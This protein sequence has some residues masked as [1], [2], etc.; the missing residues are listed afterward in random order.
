M[1]LRSKLHMEPYLLSKYYGAG[2]GSAIKSGVRLPGTAG[3]YISTPDSVLNSVMGD[4]DIRVYCKLDDWTPAA[5]MSL[6]A[7][8]NTASQRSFQIRVETNGRA[9]YVYSV[10]GN[11]GYAATIAYDPAYVDGTAHWIRFTHDVDNGAGG[12]DI[13]YYTSDDG[14]TWALRGTQTN[15]GITGVIS[16]FDSTSPLEIGSI[17]SGTAQNLLGTVYYAEVRNGIDGPVVAKFDSSQVAVTGAQLPATINGWTW[18]GAALYK[19]DDY[20][21]LPGANTDFLSYPGTAVNTI[22]GDIDVRIKLS[23]D[24]T[25]ATGT[26]AG[27]RSMICQHGGGGVIGWEFRSRAD[28]LYLEYSLD[29]TNSHSRASG[30]L[31]FADGII[32]WVRFTRVVSTGV[33]VFYASD[34]G[35]TWSIVTT[36]AALDAGS[37]FFP[38]QAQPIRIGKRSD[39]LAL[40]GNVY[41]AEVRNGINGPVVA[42]FNGADNQVQTPWTINGAAWNWEGSSFTGKPGIAYSAPQVNGNYITTPDNNALDITAALDIRAKLSLDNWADGI[43]FQGIV[44]K[45]STGQ[46]AYQLRINTDGTL[47]LLVFNAGSNVSANSTVVTGL[48]PGAVKWV[49]GTYLSDNGAGSH[50]AAY[51]LS[52]DGVV[53][54]PLGSVITTG[55]VKTIDATTAPL[56]LTTGDLGTVQLMKGKL[57]YAEVRNGIDGPIV[58]KFDPTNM[59]KTGTRTPASTVQPGGTPNMLTPN[60]ASIETDTSG[61]ANGL[62]ATLAQDATQFLD[63][64]KSLSITAIAIGASTAV[65]TPSTSPPVV[66]GKLYTAKHNMKA[67]TLGRTTGIQINWYTAANAFISSSSAFSTDVTTGWTELSITAIAPATAASA[68]VTARVTD[69]AQVLGEVH[70]VD[71]VSLVEA[72]EVW[73]INGAAWDLVN[74][75]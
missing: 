25:T 56:N 54:T 21:K 13:K 2:V 9:T 68:Q 20:V 70:Y 24:W 11:T 36:V 4:I 1:K 35:V 67:A 17:T 32:K 69:A 38:Q 75:A 34:D 29:G 33:V 26:T 71:R 52:D 19:R 53:W 10:D 28:N 60:Q 27:N 39:G 51:Y 7:K 65:T 63:G 58:A 74:A 37:P 48:A 14:I 49:R 64:T 31:S 40:P 12:H 18:N 41:Y 30:S 66:P 73:T 22:T 23:T 62:N 47:G 45:R 3:N 44:S 61:W 46:D 15:L 57:Y 59:A 55:T 16:L 42:S 8:Y 72:A 5:I 6:I 50:V 43:N